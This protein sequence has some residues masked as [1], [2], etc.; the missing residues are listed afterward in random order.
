L[1]ILSRLFGK[2]V[3]IDKQEMPQEALDG[4]RFF[5]YLRIG[6]IPITFKN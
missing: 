1:G 6:K 2:K 3:S 5:D 4:N